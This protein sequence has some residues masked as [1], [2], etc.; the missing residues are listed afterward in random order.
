MSQGSQW[1]GWDLGPGVLGFEVSALSIKQSGFIP[2]KKVK[3]G[4]INCSNTV[5][6]IFSLVKIK[7]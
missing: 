5:F 4:L 6:K 2:P 7:L 1:R 3:N